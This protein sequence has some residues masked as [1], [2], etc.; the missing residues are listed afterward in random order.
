MKG[1]SIAITIWVFIVFILTLPVF[2]NVYDCDLEYMVLDPNQDQSGIARCFAY[3]DLIPMAKPDETLLAEP[4]YRSRTPI[5]SVATFGNDKDSK[6]TLVF[7]ELGGT[8][9]GY[10]VVYLDYNN[11]ENL[12]DDPKISL[13]GVWPRRSTKYN[14]SPAVEFGPIE[15]MLNYE[16]KTLP[17]RFYIQFQTSYKKDVQTDSK[18]T[19]RGEQVDI[20]LRSG[21]YTVGDVKFGEQ[22]RRIAI[23]D[24][25]NNGVFNDLFKVQPMVELQNNYLYA[26]GDMI[27]VDVPENEQPKTLDSRPYAK[28]IN[29]DDN[30]YSLNVSEDGRRIE[31]NE[32]N[33]EFGTIKTSQNID[34]LQLNSDNGVITIN[35][36]NINEI[37]I[38]VGT[39]R[40]YGYSA[41]FTDPYKQF[42]VRGTK[43][44]KQFQIEKDKVFEMKI[45]FPVIANIYRLPSAREQ[46]P[47]KAGDSVDLSLIFTGQ[48]GEVFTHI[49]FSGKSSSKFPLPTFRVVDETDKTVAEGKFQY[50]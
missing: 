48:M 25:N 4:Q 42:Y 23:I 22:G 15:L 13:K 11:N 33:T 8:G 19:L 5:Y 12:T 50:G 45:G 30:W 32:A 40:L 44:C 37:Q 41:Q 7:D 9:K 16:G 29:I 14:D 2:A 3:K 35:E 46:G 1:K 36:K 28:Y 27:I 6:F 26:D 31:V 20:R 24:Y 10:N 34:S 21:G 47:V 17:Y 43:L 39:Y 18:K 38:P 49:L